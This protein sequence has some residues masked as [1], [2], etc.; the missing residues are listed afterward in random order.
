MRRIYN[1]SL[2]WGNF[3]KWATSRN[4]NIGEKVKGVRVYIDTDSPEGRFYINQSKVYYQKDG[5]P[6]CNKLEPS[7][8]PEIYTQIGHVYIEEFPT[9]GNTHTWNSIESFLQEIG[10]IYEPTK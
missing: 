5:E 10:V 2:I 7:V 3:Q 8:F 1:L 9:K 4:K 6:H